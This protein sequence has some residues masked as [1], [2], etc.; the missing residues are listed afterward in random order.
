[1]ALKN[2][3]EA[4]K[5][6]ADC[7][8]LFPGTALGAS[9]LEFCFCGNQSVPIV[10]SLSKNVRPT[11]EEEEVRRLLFEDLPPRKALQVL[12]VESWI[13]VET[14][15]RMMERGKCSE[16]VSLIVRG[17]GINRRRHGQRPVHAQG[18]L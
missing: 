17:T 13:T 4:P 12:S 7:D 15:E 2:Q 18:F 3:I 1:L 5:H 6:S 8:P 16:A 11:P 9:R 14:G 10:A